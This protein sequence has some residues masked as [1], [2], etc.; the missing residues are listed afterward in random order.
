MNNFYKPLSHPLIQ[1][2]YMLSCNGYIKSSLDDSIKPYYPSYHSS[3]GYDYE[4]FTLKKEHYNYF[5]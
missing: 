1:N 3:N 4:S 2:G 5:P